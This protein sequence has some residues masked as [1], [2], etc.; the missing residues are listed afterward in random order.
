MYDSGPSGHAVAAQLYLSFKKRQ[1]FKSSLEPER[2]WDYFADYSNELIDLR[3]E[4]W[5][6]QS[7]EYPQ[8]K[9][10]VCL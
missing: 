9:G 4:I 8:H 2:R 6:Q 5:Q 1:S 10:K 7:L 3:W